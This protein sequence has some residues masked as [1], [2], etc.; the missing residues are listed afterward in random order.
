MTAIG[1]DGECERERIW[2]AI[3]ADPLPQQLNN[4]RWD[5][6]ARVYGTER[7][8]RQYSDLR[9]SAK[10]I[11]HVHQRFVPTA[12]VA[13]LCRHHST[14]AFWSGKPADL[15]GDA[16]L[17]QSS[18]P[19]HDPFGPY[20][21]LPTTTDHRRQQCVQWRSR[22]PQHCLV[23]SF[24]VSTILALLILGM[25]PLRHHLQP[26]PQR[27]QNQLPHK[28]QVQA[29]LIT[30]VPAPRP[31]SASSLAPQ[32]VAWLAWPLLWP[33]SSDGACTSAARR[34]REREIGKISYL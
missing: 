7:P 5:I 13:L 1:G 3:G 2:A 19:L 27:K 34:R 12:A 14:T 23:F 18:Q 6:S 16:E 15:D 28:A 21:R 9:Y 22:D 25:T 30:R 33:Q 4:L 8:S 10:H 29:N 24:L 11:V 31:T 17:L 20:C 26:G 32:W